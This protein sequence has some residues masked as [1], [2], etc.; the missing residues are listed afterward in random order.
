MLTTIFF[1]SFSGAQREQ[2]YTN[3]GEVLVSVNP[4]KYLPITGYVSTPPSCPFRWSLSLAPLAIKKGRIGGKDYIIIFLFM[5]LANWP[6]GCL[7]SRL[8]L[9]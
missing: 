2:I 9:P 1:R 8:A 5:A 7:V 3:L 6:K 4:Y